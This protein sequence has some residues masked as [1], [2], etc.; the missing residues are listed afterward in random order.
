MK[1]LWL[2]LA[3][4][5]GLQACENQ[6]VEFEDFEYK[7]VY[8]PLQYPLR[9]LSLGEDRIDNSLDKELK[10]HIGV[11]VGGMYENTRD[12]EVSFEVDNT[13]ASNLINADGDTVEALPESYY[14]LAP[15][16]KAIIPSGSFQGLIQV[17][18]TDAFLDDPMAFKDHYMIPLKIVSSNADTVLRGLPNIANPDRRIL[19]HWDVQ[20]KDFTLF[21]IKFVNGLHGK[22]LH[23]GIDIAYDATGVAV[24]TAIYRRDY[25]VNDEV[26][27]AETSGRNSVILH[28]TGRNSG[29][30][31][32]YMM[33]LSLG[34]DEKTITVD[35][36]E[37]ANVAVTANGTCEWIKG[38]DEWGGEKRD[39]LHLSYSYVDG[40]M[41]HQ[42]QDTL[43]FRDRGIHFEEISVQVVE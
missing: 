39:V 2:I 13:L 40:A 18:L 34:T 29:E 8:F 42:V 1:K 35:A 22:Y 10:F 32:N 36:V 37:G 28:G 20:P 41:T 38:G 12:W 7:A 14:T 16:G 5:C 6:E 17:Q 19:T 15:N 24:D 30:G 43:V 4:A 21:G 23:R 9:T 31:G 3:F 26:W 25:V 11:G 27:S 33:H